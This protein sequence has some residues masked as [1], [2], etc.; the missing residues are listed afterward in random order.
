MSQEMTLTPKP[1]RESVE[2]QC[3]SKA[4][5]PTDIVAIHIHRAAVCVIQA[6]NR[7]LQ[8][9]NLVDKD[10]Y[11]TSIWVIDPVYDCKRVNH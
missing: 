8:N 5:N 6:Q 1:Q 10:Q 11:T 4:L 7:A 2:T 9:M 3:C